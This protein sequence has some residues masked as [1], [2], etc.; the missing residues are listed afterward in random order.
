MGRLDVLVCG[1][2]H[3]VFH[4]IE[5]IQQHKSKEGDCSK[6]SQFRENSNVSFYNFFIISIILHW[7]FHS[8]WIFSE[9][10]KST[11]VGIF[12]VERFADPARNSGQGCEQFLEAISEV[13]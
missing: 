8:S 4:F 7:V 1:Q 3:S 13:V 9:W 12:A 6:I 5:E 10:T 11:V 2:C